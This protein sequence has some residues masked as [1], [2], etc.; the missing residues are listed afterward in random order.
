MSAGDG[1]FDEVHHTPQGGAIDLP[2][3][4]STTPIEGVWPN[5]V[6]FPRANEYRGAF[7]VDQATNVLFIDTKALV[8]N[9]DRHPE[10][11][12]GR[13]A[14]MRII[15][16]VDGEDIDGFVIDVRN[17]GAITSVPHANVDERNGLYEFDELDRPYFY[18]PPVGIIYE[19]SS[20]KRAFHGDS[21]FEAH[22]ASLWEAVDEVVNLLSDEETNLQELERNLYHQ[23]DAV[24]TD[25]E[26]VDTA[27]LSRGRILQGSAHASARRI[28]PW[29][30][31][32]SR[33]F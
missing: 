15:D 26:E 17:T 14:I 4:A 16:Q 33:T 21:R 25:N 13:L 19:T 3:E 29:A 31:T 9:A 32:L 23:S 8:S 6:I 22:G 18:I 2:A 27:S 28:A 10:S 1:F 24:T 5:E 30:Y 11:L 7:V 20:G 12:Y